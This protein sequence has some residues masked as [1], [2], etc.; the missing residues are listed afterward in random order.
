MNKQR[1][2]LLG[3]IAG[4]IE[5]QKAELEGARDEE[6]EY[7]DNMPENMADGEKGS[8]AQE[9]IDSLEEA[10]DGLDG[11]INNLETAAQ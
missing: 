10:I 7:L 1:R 3:S 9:V 6:Q 2:G 4:A 8:A 11:A 5:E